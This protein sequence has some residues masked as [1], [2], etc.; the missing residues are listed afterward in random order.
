MT[1]LLFF[2]TI[3]FIVSYFAFDLI[4]QIKKKQPKNE[5]PGTITKPDV[6]S[7]FSQKQRY[8]EKSKKQYVITKNTPKNYGMFLQYNGKQKWSKKI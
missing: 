1:T 7:L 2:I 3:Y 6:Q 5:L 8:K 4:K